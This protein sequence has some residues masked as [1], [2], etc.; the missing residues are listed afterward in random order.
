MPIMFKLLPLL[1]LVLGILIA[2][3]AV[4]AERH[5]PIAGRTGRSVVM[6]PHGMVATSQPDR[7]RCAQKWR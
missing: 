6:A 4:A 1:P 2:L 3:A 7:P 5:T